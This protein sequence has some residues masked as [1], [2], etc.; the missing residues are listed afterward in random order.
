MPDVAF[1]NCAEQRIGDGMAKN[2]RIGMAFQSAV[3]R[4]LDTPENEFAT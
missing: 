3:I 4:N 1:V 2:V